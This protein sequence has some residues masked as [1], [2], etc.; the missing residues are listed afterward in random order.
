MIVILWKERTIS[1]RKISKRKM[2]MSEETPEVLFVNICTD[3]AKLDRQKYRELRTW[4]I[5]RPHLEDW[6]E[7]MES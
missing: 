7:L 6:T 2:T 5:L 3:I 4:L 1:K